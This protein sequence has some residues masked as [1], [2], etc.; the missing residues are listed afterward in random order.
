M[1]NNKLVGRIVVI[2]LT[3]ILS[4]LTFML[5]FGEALLTLS[6][7]LVL[8]AVTAFIVLF[9]VLIILY[10]HYLFGNNNYRDF[11]QYLDKL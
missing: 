3:T 1:N 10:L 11:N 5:G 8:I 2:S 7:T 6:T 4:V 9:L